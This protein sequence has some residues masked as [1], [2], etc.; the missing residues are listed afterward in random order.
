MI[1]HGELEPGVG[2]HENTTLVPPLYPG[3]L[4]SDD[5]SLLCTGGK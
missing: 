1:L 4:F 5:G 2:D 3:I